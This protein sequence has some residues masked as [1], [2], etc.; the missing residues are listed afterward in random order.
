MGTT[1]GRGAWGRMDICLCM[2]ESL[3]YPP[4]IITAL[5]IDSQFSS[6]QSLCCV[7]LF[8][9]PWT[10]AR[11]APLSMRILQARILEW[12]AMPSSRGSSQPRDHIQVSHIAGGFFTSWATRETQRFPKKLRVTIWSSMYPEQMKTLIQKDTC[13]LGFITPLSTIAKTWKQPECP[14]TEEWIK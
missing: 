10:V 1:N 14:S 11:Q 4:E 6:V 2:A 9:T 8:V 5:L 3:C 13:T 12:V 7:Q